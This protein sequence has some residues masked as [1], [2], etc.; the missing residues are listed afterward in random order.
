MDLVLEL[1]GGLRWAI[2]INR[3]SAPK[4]SKGFH[5]ARA[6]LEPERCFVVDAG[7]ERYPLAAGVEAIGVA[8]LADLLRKP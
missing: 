3:S 6:D 8:E 1:P 2:E 7:H 5:Q 4:L